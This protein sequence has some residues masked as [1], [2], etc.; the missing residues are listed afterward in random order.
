M[1]AQDVRH[2]RMKRQKIQAG[3]TGKSS[4]DQIQSVKK[5]LSAACNI[6]SAHRKSEQV[7]GFPGKINYDRQTA[8][9]QKYQRHAHITHITGKGNPPFPY[10]EDSHNNQHKT[11]DRNRPAEHARAQTENRKSEFL[12]CIHIS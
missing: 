10:T 3:H 6:D 2:G 8:E 1:N 12:P 9:K 5:R 11:G 7:K 4:Q